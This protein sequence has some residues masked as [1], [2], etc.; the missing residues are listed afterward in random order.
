M[1]LIFMTQ[2]LNMKDNKYNVKIK[3]YYDYSKEWTQYTRIFLLTLPALSSGR[4]Q[5]GM[6]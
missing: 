4:V 3:T 1:I 6:H 5:R 2:L